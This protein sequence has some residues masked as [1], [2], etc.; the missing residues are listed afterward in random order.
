MEFTTLNN[1]KQTCDDDI[2]NALNCDDYQSGICYNNGDLIQSVPICCNAR[3]SCSFSTSIVTSISNLN[4][5]GIFN[6]SIRIDSYY[7]VED[8][9]G[10]IK[11]TNGGNMYFTGIDCI[12]CIDCV[13]IDLSQSVHFWL[14]LE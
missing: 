5:N 13:C 10:I 2:T 11:A 14:M 12:D 9:T 7:G 1:S 3:E 8:T 4:G 6:T